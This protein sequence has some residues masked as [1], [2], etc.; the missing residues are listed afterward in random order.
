[1]ASN[2]SLSL[3]LWAALAL[4]LVIASCPVTSTNPEA[5]Q[6]AVGGVEPADPKDEEVQ[7][8]V[9]FAVETYND[10]TKDA[11]VSKPIQVISAGQQVVYGK[12]FY[13]KIMLGRTTCAKGQ[14]VD[15]DDCPFNE[16]PDQQECYG[17]GDSYKPLVTPPFTLSF[18]EVFFIPLILPF[19]T[20]LVL[21]QVLELKKPRDPESY[22]LD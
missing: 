16:L 6:K 17:S 22:S 11:Y 19:M 15:L 8:A 18:S 3:S 12:N 1:M 4:T 13:L 10:L 14:S 21:V 20:L 7:K 2:Q 5:N 9:D